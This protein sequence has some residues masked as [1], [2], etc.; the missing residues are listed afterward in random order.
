MI[1]WY[2][3]ITFY[4]SSYIT[5]YNMEYMNENKRTT[6]CEKLAFKREAASI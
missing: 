6:N 5:T 1:F 2:M 4:V 3:C